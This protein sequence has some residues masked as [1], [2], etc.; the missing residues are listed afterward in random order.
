MQPPH[1]N[2]PPAGGYGAGATGGRFGPAAGP[3]GDGGG[4]KRPVVIT[5][6]TVMAV[7]MMVGTLTV[8]GAF[9]T[10]KYWTGAKTAE[11]KNSLG[12]MAKDAYTAYESE[13]PLDATSVH[14]LCRGASFPV[15]RDPR[16]ISGKKYQSSPA[17]W[18]VDA[19]K[20]A[21]FACLHFSMSAPQY[22]QYGYEATA[23]SFR[24]IGRGDMNGNGRFSEF[25]TSGRVQ[26]SRLIIEPYI[27]ETDPEE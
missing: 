6:V 12:Q 24:G 26:D 21:G 16:A 11:A 18:E 17:D 5:I 3:R 19:A 15:P 2:A 23:T 10:R 1:E 8:L 22:Y 4:G 7:L 9:L 14:R 13:D 25:T 27:S 20:N